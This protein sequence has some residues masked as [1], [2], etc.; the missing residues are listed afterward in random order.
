[1]KK[2]FFLTL[3]FMLLMTTAGRAQNNEHNMVIKLQNGTTITL[4]PD[5][6]QNITFNGETINVEG[7]TIEEIKQKIEMLMDASFTAL[8]TTQAIKEILGDG[9]MEWMCRRLEY[10]RILE[11][12]DVLTHVIELEKEK[13]NMNEMIQ[14]MKGIIDELEH[15][16]TALENK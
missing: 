7:N 2:N 11:D 8:E 4:G 13:D 10:L 1:M 16:V 12:Y 3:L 15:R 14:A 9:N 5:D 6:L